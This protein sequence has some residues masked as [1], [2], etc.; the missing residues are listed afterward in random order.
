MSTKSTKKIGTPV[1]N[2]KAIPAALK[3]AA[4][5]KAAPG[6]ATAL[7]AKAQD[8][9]AKLHV[10]KGRAEAIKSC[11]A[12]ASGGTGL[13]VTTTRGRNIVV[14]RVDREVNRLTKLGEPVAALETYLKTQPKPQAKLAQ[15]VDSHN[16][17]HSAKAVA[18]ARGKANA[19]K[20]KGAKAAAP[21]AGKNKQPAK[22]T[23]RAYK[24][25]SREDTSRPDTWR[26]HMLTMIMRNKDMDSAKAAHAKSG[27]FADN[28]LDFNWANQQDYIKFTN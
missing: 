6:N 26:R 22:G 3:R 21:K 25:G 13:C 2:G 15:G 17:P 1:R 18:D 27:K 19:T 9:L 5:A 11:S 20:G 8:N 23:N 10:T 12:L 28:K 16:S 4:K 24:L 14:T 7:A